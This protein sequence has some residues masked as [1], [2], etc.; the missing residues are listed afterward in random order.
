MNTPFLSGRPLLVM[1]SLLLTGCFSSREVHVW[2]YG[3][4][5]PRFFYEVIPFQEEAGL[6]FIEVE[7]EGKMRKFLFDTGAPNVISR[8]LRQ[9]LGLGATFYRKVR[10]SNNRRREL[11]GVTLDSLRIGELLFTDTRAIVADLNEVTL[12][13]CLDID[14]FI[15]ANLMRLAKWQIDF[16]TRRITISDQISQLPTGGGIPVPFSVNGQ[17][18]PYLK[19]GIDG[20]PVKVELDYGS[21]G[22]FSLNRHLLADLPGGRI[23]NR[24]FGL[25]SI[26]LY[27]GMDDTV[28]HY[29][30]GQIQLGNLLFQDQVIKF[31]SSGSAL[32]GTDVF[33]H[34]IVTFDWER[35]QLY[36]QPLHD[37]PRTYQSFGL[38][39]LPRYGKMIVARVFE[40]SPASRAG[41]RIDDEVRSLNGRPA[42][43]WLK[44]EGCAL[45]HF[46]LDTESLPDSLPLEFLRDGE[47]RQVSLEPA[48]LYQYG[49]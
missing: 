23:V 4:L 1:L 18:T 6:I 37:L 2:E 14:G 10:D 17:G 39:I 9:E 32:I 49:R 38:V 36:L 15:G 31:E 41:L 45:Y 21:T 12:F 30:F 27:G 44:N 40:N 16:S 43:T 46:F 3:R 7:L 11:S 33:R 47:L 26:G 25:S 19:L 28:T 42:Y 24:S 20:V 48:D 5:Q 34:F 29:R 13:D 8:E 35:Y 22:G